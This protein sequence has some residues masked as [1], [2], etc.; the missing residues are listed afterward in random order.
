MRPARAADYTNNEEINIAFFRERDVKIT[1]RVI[2]METE[3]QRAH[4]VA[5]RCAAVVLRVCFS[6]MLIYDY[7]DR[8][9]FHPPV[10]P[11]ALSPLLRIRYY[12]MGSWV[13]WSFRVAL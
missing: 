10:R 11:L 5:V 2:S 13:L 6:S 3:S 9:R 1:Q 8:N 7:D 12:P 4:G